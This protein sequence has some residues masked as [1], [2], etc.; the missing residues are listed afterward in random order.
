MMGLLSCGS[1][2]A[3]VCQVKQHKV[4]HLQAQTQLTE[5][6]SLERTYLDHK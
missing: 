5:D 6:L 2:C 3:K 4:V 1:S